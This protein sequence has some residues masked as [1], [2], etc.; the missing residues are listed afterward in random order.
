M[1]PSP[2]LIG[3]ASITN[4]VSVGRVT[5]F[6]GFLSLIIAPRPTGPQP[7]DGLR[8]TQLSYHCASAGGPQPRDGMRRIQPRP[9]YNR[10]GESIA[11]PR[12]WPPAGH[13]VRGASAPRLPS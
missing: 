6:I 8:R 10:P 9:D 5:P 1:A 2:N 4:T 12:P 13:E 11:A 3:E 7:R